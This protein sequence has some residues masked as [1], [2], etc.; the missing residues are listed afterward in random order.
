MKNARGGRTGSPSSSKTAQNRS[1]LDFISRRDCSQKLSC[2][3]SRYDV[4]VSYSSFFSLCNMFLLERDT[5]RKFS[6][7]LI[8]RKRWWKAKRETYLIRLLEPYGRGFLERRD[9]TIAD[10]R[11]RCGHVVDKVGRTYKVPH[12]PPGGVK[13]LARRAYG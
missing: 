6:L 7:R 2:W 1:T 8:I 3:V 4:S 10:A 5:I 9:T 13:I 12:A 11:V